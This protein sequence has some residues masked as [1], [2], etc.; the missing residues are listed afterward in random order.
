[1]STYLHIINGRIRIKLPQVKGDPLAASQMEQTLL[2]QDGI[3]SVHANPVTGNVLVLFDP[4][5][6]S[7]DRVLE[8]L[9]PEGDEQ[10]NSHTTSTVLAVSNSLATVFV[11]RVAESF[12]EHLARTAVR[13]AVERLIFAL[14]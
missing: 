4:A 2:E 13:I 11:T 8:I 1:M 12:G 5:I 10:K 7:E 6:I 3:T 9:R 14:I